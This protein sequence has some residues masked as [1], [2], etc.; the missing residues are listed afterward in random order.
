MNAYLL[1][2]YVSSHL[3][4][5]EDQ[6]LGDVLAHIALNKWDVRFP[7]RVLLAGYCGNPS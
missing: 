1:W 2:S 3:L 7:G 5:M 6:S 4:H